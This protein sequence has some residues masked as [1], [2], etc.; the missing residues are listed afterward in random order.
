MHSLDYY[1]IEEKLQ[2]VEIKVTMGILIFAFSFVL[3]I[4]AN[5]FYKRAKSKFHDEQILYFEKEIKPTIVICNLIGII[6]VL[7]FTLSYFIF[8]FEIL[9]YF[10]YMF[11]IIMIWEGITFY[12]LNRLISLSPFP[13][14]YNITKINY[15]LNQVSRLL[16]LIALKV[17]LDALL[18]VS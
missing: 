8:Y 18:L 6:P 13:K 5:I 4:T 9:D 11:L 3:L 15:L 10:W 17:F 7:I 12:K 14:D 2:Q 1:Q 16:A